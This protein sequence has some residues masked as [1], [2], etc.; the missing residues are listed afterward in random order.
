[1][2][3]MAYEWEKYGG[4]VNAVAPTF[5]ETAMTADTFKDKAFKGYIFSKLRLPPLAKGEEVVAGVLYLASSGADIYDR[6]IL[7]IDGGWSIH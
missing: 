4:A 1:M 7:Y 6:S 3:V 2:R 5:V